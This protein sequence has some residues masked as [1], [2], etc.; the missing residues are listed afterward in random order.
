MFYSMSKLLLA[1]LVCIFSLQ[2]FAEIDK[3]SNI[4]V[5]Q[6]ISYYQ[7]KI[8]NNKRLYSAYN[9]LARAYFDKAK[10]SNNPVLL[11]KA[12]GLLEQS[13]GIQE[14]FEAYKVYAVISNY[15]HRFEEALKWSLKAYSASPLDTEITA[16]RVEALIGLGKNA[17]ARRLL[18]ETIEGVDDFYIAAALGQWYSASARYDQAHQAFL[19]AAKVAK[20]NDVVELQN[21]ATVNAAGMCIDDGRL[22]EALPFLEKVKAKDANNKDLLLHYAEVHIAKN[23]LAKG[24]A[25]YSEMLKQDND[26]A[27]HHFAY[28]LAK[29]LKLTDATRMHYLA[30]ESGYQAAINAGEI[31]TLGAMARLYCDADI[32]LEVAYK[33][34]SRNLTF[35]R[36]TLAHESFE[37]AKAKQ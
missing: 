37:R 20:E 17:D 35:K 4:D 21:W 3:K 5:D 15:T 9:L 31:Y 8:D 23:E 1:S 11:D 14:N 34:A 18:P 25:L 24:F 28:L 26:P 2:A 12:R 33:L 19:A 10:I 7:N 22:Q 36:D 16:T 13:I 30:A 32:K 27:V 29:K 6:R